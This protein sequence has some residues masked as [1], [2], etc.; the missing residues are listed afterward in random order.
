MQVPWLDRSNFL[1]GVRV[2]LVRTRC[3]HDDLVARHGHDLAVDL[4]DDDLARVRSSACLHTR[5]H[6]RGVGPD[7]RHGLALHVRAH[8]G[9]VRIVVLEEGNECGGDRNDLLRRHV[10]VVDL[11]G[12]DRVDVAARLPNEHAVVDE[13]AIVVQ[14]G[15]RLSDDVTLFLGS[16]QV[17]DPLGDLAVDDPAVRGL[18]E[19][20]AVHPAV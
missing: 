7:E 19:A 1:S 2:L 16:G 14:L 17:V 13:R 10:H 15:V 18:D 11:V 5:T 12:Y 4:T 9:T 20:E 8:Q 3:L 6:E